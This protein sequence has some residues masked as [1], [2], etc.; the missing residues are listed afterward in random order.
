MEYLTK[1]ND[2]GFNRQTL[3]ALVGAETSILPDYFSGTGKKSFL[4]FKNNKYTTV[5]TKNVAF[6]YI[7]H[8]SAVLV[9]FD[10]QEYVLNYSL[11]HIQEMLRSDEFY[12]LNRQYLVNFN[13]VKE[14]EHYFARKL[15][16]N[17]VIPT[18]D[19]LVVSKEKM[20][21]FLQWLDNR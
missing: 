6:F 1:I 11:E 12:R 15:L 20:R 2:N 16:V 9:T 21:G 17:L 18:K 5:P 3:H 8:T 13:A 10:G 19:K 14:V 7:N 4:V